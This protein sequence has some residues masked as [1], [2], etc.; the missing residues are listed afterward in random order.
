MLFNGRILKD[1]Y[2]K[3]NI[4]CH[5]EGVRSEYASLNPHSRP[6]FISLAAAGLK[7]CFLVP[8]FSTYKKLIS[9]TNHTRPPLDHRRLSIQRIS[10]SKRRG[11]MPSVRLEDCTM[12]VKLESQLTLILIMV[13]CCDVLRTIWLH[14]LR[15]QDPTEAISPVGGRPLLK[16]IQQ[17]QF[18]LVAEQVSL[19]MTNVPPL[20]SSF[21]VYILG[22]EVE[23]RSRGNTASRNKSHTRP[24]ES[25]NQHVE[26]FIDSYIIKLIPFLKTMILGNTSNNLFSK[27]RMVQGS[28]QLLYAAGKKRI[29]YVSGMVSITVTYRI[30][31]LA[32]NS[33]N[34]LHEPVKNNGWEV[35]EPKGFA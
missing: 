3:G 18:I 24:V 25:R 23:H 10:D 32:T 26:H 4:L 30:S 21:F 9:C 22:T 11:G 1:M 12:K 8:I 19:L 29:S 20:T 15:D 2:Q 33:L 5:Y 27:K 28:P 7:C 6:S 31:G 34:R 35:A 17:Y 13:W 16:G 14:S